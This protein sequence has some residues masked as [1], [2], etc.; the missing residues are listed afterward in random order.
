MNV[1]TANDYLRSLELYIKDL[2]AR[3]T[4]ATTLAKGAIIAYREC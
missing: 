2:N 3:L 1:H 4:H